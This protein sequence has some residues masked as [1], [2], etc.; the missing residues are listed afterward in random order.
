MSEKFRTTYTKMQAE[1][2]PSERL[3]EH[4]ISAV[5]TKSRRNPVRLRTAALVAAVLALLMALSLPVLAA[6]DAGYALLYSVS[7][8]TAEFFRP[9]NLSDEDLG[10]RAE[11][12][13]IHLVDDTI[14][15]CLALQDQ[16]SNRIDENMELGGNWGVVPSAPGIFKSELSMAS[17]SETFM[18][19]DAE[20]DT[21]RYLL[22][23]SDITEQRIH[24]SYLLSLRIGRFFSGYMEFESLKLPVID[25]SSTELNPEM[26]QMPLTGYT[27]Q[28]IDSEQRSLTKLEDP[29]KHDYTFLKPAAEKTPLSDDLPNIYLSKTGYVENN[30]HIQLYYEDPLFEESHGILWLETADGERIFSHS[31]ASSLVTD[32]SSTPTAAYEEFIFDISSEE[33]EGCT[34]HGS[35]RTCEAIVDGNWQVTFPLKETN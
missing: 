3:I 20:T 10:I 35:L 31:A 12:E 2:A 25:L 5:Q 32:E 29:R 16:E 28:E 19:Y 4:T 9:I 27:A 13:S 8:E 24:S 30:L 6:T 21:A 22:T 23:F 7:P 14:Q 26:T 33:L 18:G 17:S 11:V 15:I 34:V 1:I